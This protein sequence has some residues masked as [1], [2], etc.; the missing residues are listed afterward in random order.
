MVS[1]VLLVD[2]AFGRCEKSRIGMT[3]ATANIT[4][5]SN[6]DRLIIL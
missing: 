4:E 6:I 5:L 1:R 2:K 3:G